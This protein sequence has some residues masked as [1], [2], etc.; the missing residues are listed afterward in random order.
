MPPRVSRVEIPPIETVVKLEGKAAESRRLGKTRLH[1]DKNSL[2]LTAKS[3]NFL[4]DA[5]GLHPS[6]KVRDAIEAENVLTRG[7]GKVRDQFYKGASG[8]SCVEVSG[9]DS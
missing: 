5:V 9:G 4:L 2:S 6:V 8:D 3:G 1:R 7:A